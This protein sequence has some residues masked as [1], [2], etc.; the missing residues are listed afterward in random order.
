MDLAWAATGRSSCHGADSLLQAFF[1]M[2]LRSSSTYKGVWEA[3]RL[4]T[5][6]KSEPNLVTGTS[7][8]WHEN[9]CT[10][11]VG[12]MKYAPPSKLQLVC[13][14]ARPAMSHGTHVSSLT[15]QT[16]SCEL[17]NHRLHQANHQE[18]INVLR[19][20]YGRKLPIENSGNS[21]VPLKKEVW[22]EL[23]R[24]HN[25]RS[26]WASYDRVR[27]LGAP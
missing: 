10:S 2:F 11:E 23:H 9:T 19:T 7:V 8:K 27:I 17:N 25:P 18:H 13:N 6:T 12:A 5:P 22:Q 24:H 16:H 3:L 14:L 1:A 15:W 26:A 21:F 20:M 4:Q